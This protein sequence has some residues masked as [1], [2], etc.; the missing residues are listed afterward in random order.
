MSNSDILLTVLAADQA[1]EVF[2][3]DGQFKVLARG[4]QSV[5]LRIPPGIYRAKVRVGNMQGEKLF[6]VEPSEP[7][8]H[9]LVQLDAIEFSSPIP[10][11]RTSTTHEYRQ[12]A[13]RDEMR[14]A[15]VPT[16][17]LGTG[18]GL[19]IFLRDPS[20]L[21]S[22]LDAASLESYAKNFRGFLLSDWDGQ[23]C[24]ALDEIGMLDASHGY[25]MLSAT[26]NPGAYALSRPSDNTERLS[27]PLVV[28]DNWSLQ[29]FVTMDPAGHN[30]LLLR[31]NF[32]DAAMA[33]ERPNAVFSPSRPDLNVLELARDALARGHNIIGDRSM[34]QLLA[35]KVENPMMGI[36]AAHLLLLDKNPNLSL[37]ETVVANTATLIGADYP[38][39]LALSWKLNYSKYV[40][41]KEGQAELDAVP[42][43]G[44]LKYPPLLQLSW[45]YLMQAYRSAPD[46]ATFDAELRR[47][48][49]RL[50]SSSVWLCWTSFPTPVPKLD[51]ILPERES[52]L[53]TAGAEAQPDALAILGPRLNIVV[54]KT[55][56]WFTKTLKEFLTA[57]KGAR[58][59]EGVNSQAKVGGDT[60]EETVGIML[61]AEVFQLLVQSVDWA[62][63]VKYLK[64]RNLAKVSLNML[65]PLQ[66]RL[67]LSLK[68]ARE[69][70]EE[71]GNISEDSLARWLAASDIP[72]GALL[73]NLK[74]L[75][76][77][78]K[79]IVEVISHSNRP[80]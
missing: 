46:E 67:L 24:H 50:I 63:V 6:S 41:T 4:I 49:G 72:S 51:A 64:T 15:P 78:A 34:E 79:D 9:K 3:I 17:N 29:V 38:D 33:F 54:R 35:G 77:Y 48:S 56:D 70:F 58:P 13:L 5:E 52:L 12:Q 62:A 23:N 31:A 80:S 30:A 18:A 57:R 26:V 76:R 45:H 11:E 20:T 28:P 74:F 53:M 2:V 39:L 25:L 71:D 37:A 69:Q 61:A 27:L 1:S 55:K 65:S 60:G 16:V 36:F 22:N 73:D 44:R 43:L 47:L 66:R 32:N 19:V 7:G 59:P 42:L 10:L 14:V 68:A 40:R 21:Y 75:G 8:N